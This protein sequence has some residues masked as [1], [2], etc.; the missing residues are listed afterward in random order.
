MYRGK[1]KK[2][3]R[4]ERLELY[5]IL[6]KIY[7]PFIKI[8]WRFLFWDLRYL[9]DVIYQEH[10]MVHLECMI[11]ISKSDYIITSQL[12]N[13]FG[14]W[15]IIAWSLIFWKNLSIELLWRDIGDVQMNEINALPSSKD[16]LYRLFK[17]PQNFWTIKISTICRMRTDQK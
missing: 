2:I 9:E 6:S 4:R 14:K 15:K 10:K 8:V 7:F 13:P 16:I 11:L 3:D 12:M 17:K 1:S 5:F